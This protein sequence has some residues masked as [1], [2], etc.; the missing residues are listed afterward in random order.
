MLV[1]KE[2]VFGFIYDSSMGSVEKVY[3]KPL[4]QDEKEMI[5]DILDEDTCLLT[6]IEDCNDLFDINSNDELM[7]DEEGLSGVFD[8]V[9]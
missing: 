1:F 2:N 6:Q 9:E 3:N 5:W 4:T 7:S 8:F